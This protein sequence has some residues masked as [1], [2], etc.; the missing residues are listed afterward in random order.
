MNVEIRTEAAQIPEKEYIY[1][2]FAA[3]LVLLFLLSCLLLIF[4]A[5]PPAKPSPPLITA[6]TPLSHFYGPAHP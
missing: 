3:L 4:I 2:I 5:Q 6:L 1:G